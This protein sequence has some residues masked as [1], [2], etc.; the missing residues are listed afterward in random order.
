VVDEELKEMVL[1]GS[2]TEIEGT[3]EDAEK[4]TA[5]IP[6]DEGTSFE[7]LL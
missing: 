2:G 5:C 6:S 1:D 3:D 4:E 7:D